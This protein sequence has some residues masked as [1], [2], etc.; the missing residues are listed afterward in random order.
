MRNLEN[1]INRLLAKLT[2]QAGPWVPPVAVY[3][4]NIPGDIDRVAAEIKQAAIDA[5]WT[6]SAGP[7][8]ALIPT[9]GREVVEV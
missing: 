9:N 4:P 1:R 2:P 6:E 3:D 8:V 5:G 7:Y